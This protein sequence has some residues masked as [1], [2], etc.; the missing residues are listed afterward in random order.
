MPTRTTNEQALAFLAFLLLVVDSVGGLT[1]IWSDEEV[2]VCTARWRLPVDVLT[3]VAW[4]AAAFAHGDRARR[5]WR[6]LLLVTC[7]AAL[8]LTTVIGAIAAIARQM[9]CGHSEQCKDWI[10]ACES[11]GVLLLLLLWIACVSR[12]SEGGERT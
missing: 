3:L 4:A 11:S 12:R 6:S 5:L 7:P 8:I 2:R 10:F 9:R 1:P